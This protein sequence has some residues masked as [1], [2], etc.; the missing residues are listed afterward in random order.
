MGLPE[1][2]SVAVRVGWLPLA[3]A[4]LVAG[5][6]GPAVAAVEVSLLAVLLWRSHVGVTRTL[7]P[8]SAGNVFRDDR[9]V[10]SL[11]TTAA[12]AY[13]VVLVRVGHLGA[14]DP[15]A[16]APVAAIAAT[17]A[18]YGV[19]AVAVGGY[20]LG[21]Y[22][23][24]DG[25]FARIYCRLL[26]A[27]PA[28][29]RRREAE[30]VRDALAGRSPPRTRVV[31]LAAATLAVGSVAAVAAFPFG[32]LGGLLLAHRLLLVVVVVAWLGVDAVA[33]DRAPAL[34]DV[35]R[36][37]DRP[38]RLLDR[39]ELE[40]WG[41][42]GLFAATYAVSAGL[43]VTV[44]LAASAL[45]TTLAGPPVHAAG[46]AG[47]VP[48]RLVAVAAWFASVGAAVL[49]ASYSFLV[50]Y[51]LLVRLPKWV[52]GDGAS[53]VALP[54]P[55][56]CAYPVALVAYFSLAGPATAD[57]EAAARVG[58]LA[59]ALAAAVVVGGRRMRSV[60]LPAATAA[61]DYYRILAFSVVSFGVPSLVARP[62]AWPVLSVLFAGVAMVYA[63]PAVVARAGRAGGPLAAGLLVDGYVATATAL[64]ALPAG[65]LLSAH[66]LAVA[67]VSVVTVLLFGATLVD[68]LLL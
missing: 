21:R 37:V 32:V 44:L 11:V 42:E 24:P 38:G 55:T 62:H 25:A 12:L 60:R 34:R 49:L 2:V 54:G 58:A 63:V 50:W 13:G 46:T 53:A 14:P 28:V 10:R 22:P 66:V 1:R 45:A 7:D 39:L 43:V 64:V 51:A 27:G 67:F 30:R 4:N 23:G 20:L 17:F 6:F 65:V 29:L 35:A 8:R 41:L 48:P 15:A 56:D 59:A 36:G 61:G 47:G 57:A 16:G 3:V 33:G 40:E 68:H 5:W 26:D 31:F 52:D 18:V 9:G 19:A